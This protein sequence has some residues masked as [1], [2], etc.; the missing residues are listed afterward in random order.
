MRYSVSPRYEFEL[1][2]SKLS[3]LNKWISPVELKAALDK[4]QYAMRSHAGELSVGA[5][6]QDKPPAP[7]QTPQDNPG[8]KTNN[9]LPDELRRMM[10]AKTRPASA[11]QPMA[12]QPAV[13]Q[14][15]VNEAN[16][17]DDEPI[18]RTGLQNSESQNNTSGTKESTNAESPVDRVLRIIPGTVIK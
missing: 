6:S 14:Q 13:A 15:A 1:A 12:A 11:A 4:A 5:V 10:A 16:D 2:I 17:D 7:R 9:S 3:W 18:W 8:P